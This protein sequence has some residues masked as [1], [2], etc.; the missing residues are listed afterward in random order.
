MHIQIFINSLPVQGE[1][2]RAGEGIIL[3]VPAVAQQAG[4]EPNLLPPFKKLFQPVSGGFIEVG[5]WDGKAYGF[6]GNVDL[7]LGPDGRIWAEVCD[8]AD[9]PSYPVESGPPTIPCPICRGSG[10]IH[11]TDSASRKPYT[12][13]CSLCW[14]TG[15]IPA[16]DPW[17]EGDIVFA[18]GYWDC[19]CDRNYVH[20][21]N[22]DACPVCGV[23][24]EEQPVSRA[25]EV[26]AYL[27]SFGLEVE[28][29]E[30]GDALLPR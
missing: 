26:R 17:R 30:A 21:C 23:A 20:P 1:A 18:L 28:T 7:G 27:A 22:H 4:E 24:A 29:Q 3:H 5:E 13:R 16:W 11:H 14:G 6:E 2:Y 12:G 25:D 15:E 9:I 19:E 10:V 8:P